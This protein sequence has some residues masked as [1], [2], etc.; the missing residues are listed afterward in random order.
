MEEDSSNS[1]NSAFS[2]GK[3]A[4]EKGLPYVPDC[5]Q[6]PPSN[7]PS[8]SPEIANV[9][10][11]DLSGLRQGSEQRSIVVEDIRNACRRFGF[12]QVR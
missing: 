9:P 8:L 5:Y 12:F 11:V 10:V 3:S 4:Q 2:T 6:I 7:R 1:S